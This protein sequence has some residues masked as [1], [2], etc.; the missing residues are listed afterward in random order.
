MAKQFT[1]ALY[2]VFASVH[3]TSTVMG[4]FFFLP[5]LLK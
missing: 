3:E 5:R 2:A 4:F 1:R